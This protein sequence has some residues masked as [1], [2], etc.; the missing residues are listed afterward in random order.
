[1]TGKLSEVQKFIHVS[2]Y[3]RWIESEGR[4]ETS[5]SE[6][7]GRY[8]TFMKERFGTTV[9]K[10]VW[11]VIETRLAE[12]G[13]VPSMRAVA[14]AGPPLEANNI[15]AYNC[16]F[17]P[18]Q[19]L[20]AVMELFYIL[21]CGTGVG[22]SVENHW[23][24]QMP[25]VAKWSGDGAGV[26]VVPDDREGW[27]NSL[28]IGLESWFG[29]KDIE[30]DY[31][32]IRPRGSKLKMTGGR[33]SGPD[34]LRDLHDFCR[35]TICRAQGRQL[36]QLEWLDIG[37]I[38]ADIVVVGG[39]RR[40]SEI[41]FSDL[42]DSAMRTA[43]DIGAPK[44]RANSNNS[45]VF[46]YKPEAHV[47]LREWL[48]LVESNSGERGIFNLHAVKGTMPARRKFSWEMRT[49]PCGEIILRPFSFCNL[50][51]VVVRAA[52]DF[53][54][55]VEKVEAAVWM[56][57]MQS[58]L[59]KF[60]LLRKEFEEN[61]K[62]ERLLG[63]SLTGQMDN[64][65]LMTAEKLAILKKYAIKTAKKA[66]SCLG[67][68]LSAS[69]T[70]GKPSGTVSQLVSAASGAHPQFAPYY[71]RR[72]R[73]NAD[74]PVYAMMKSQGVEFV[75]ENDQGPES[76]AVK[77]KALIERGRTEKEAKILV[78]DW[79]ESQVRT[80]VCG[81]PVAAPKGAVTRQDVDAIGQLEWYL[82]I[83]RNWIE[84]NQSITVYVKPEE[85]VKVGA[86]VYDHFDEIVGI[87]FLPF[88][89][90][91]YKLAPYSDL[92][93]EEYEKILK[94]FPKLDW[95]QLP[96]FETDDNTVSAQTL[97]CTGGGCDV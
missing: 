52:D 97:A 7:S 40:S 93:Q 94:A 42:E 91:H 30:F 92:T 63:V 35:D 20:R 11:N 77:R 56:G 34:P 28:L 31:S 64:P 85:W 65:K 75:P 25:V 10:K 22:F 58:T 2:K 1:M 74:D 3:S 80:W 36:T 78:P 60:P 17:V 86:W 71:L 50:S 62:E 57:A 48:H 59:T 12:L 33:A 27:A 13:V 14:M 70:C 24:K 76:V 46:M 9:P 81:F 37:N 87:T 49:N 21:M 4:R 15:M 41:C 82:K 8:L 72:Y 29:G 88:D 44:W 89:G 67:I 18:F 73:L 26:H 16:S 5:W 19:D 32:K 95:T 54:D 51:E 83:M 43:K 39:V 66:A 84:H 38:I 96:K 6:T 53:D 79:D 90:G 69:I 47:F 23:I 61:C 55:L 45:A 68:P